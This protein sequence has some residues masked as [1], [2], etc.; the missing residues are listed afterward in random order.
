MDGKRKIH[1]FPVGNN[2]EGVPFTVLFVCRSVNDFSN[3]A[4]DII[5]FRT[6]LVKSAQ[7]SG[8]KLKEI[9]SPLGCDI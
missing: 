8:L 3:S 7:T 1:S 6:E 9:G 2:R 5:H 4:K